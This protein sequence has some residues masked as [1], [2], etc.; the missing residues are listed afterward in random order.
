MNNT[1][2]NI[3]N[4]T[5]LW[6][7]ASAP[8]QSYFENDFFCYARIQDMQWPNRVWAK[9]TILPE[10]F[11]N[12]SRFTTPITFSHF[13]SMDQEPFQNENPNIRFKSKQY[14]MSLPLSN[15]FDI[16]KE[17]IFKKVDTNIDANL[18]SSSFYKAFGYEINPE[19][20]LKTRHHIPFYLVFWEK[21]LVG[22]VIIFKTHEIVGIHALGIIPTMRKKG[23]ATEI[24]KQ[25]INISIDQH[26]S[27]A[28][29]QAS[30]MAK[31]MYQRMGF[32]VDFLMYNYEVC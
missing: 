1:K 5:T 3:D 30:E 29:L 14:G 20:I 32:S 22:T 15:E 25:I 18:W 4:L 24:M 6:K 16:E 19:V 17:L 27:F 12:V 2:I 8:F 10:N 31:N 13:I 21:E 7:T 28:T 9:N 23:F 26:L 11:K